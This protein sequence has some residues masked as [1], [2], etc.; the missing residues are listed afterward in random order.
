MDTSRHIGMWIVVCICALFLTP[1]LRNHESMKTYVNTEVELTRSV[2]GDRVGHWIHTQAQASY[3]L[4]PTQRLKA[5]E[6]DR[7]G[8]DRT[9]KVTAGTGIAVANAFNRYVD[10]LVMNVYVL[11][12]RLFVLLIW[13]GVLL[14]VFVAAVI[15]GLVS[16]AIKRVEFGAIRPAAFVAT[17]TA[18]IPLLMAPFVYLV[19]PLPVS[20][21]V[22][23]LWAMVTVLPLA[24]LVSNMQPLF[25]RN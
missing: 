24:L 21:L 14:P 3:R 15:D 19:V 22:A 4:I 7:A 25:G 11:V 16:R 13:T 18:V 1:L 8:M 20:P 10:G 9:R 23:P 2:F 12:H 17:A 6:I 5:A